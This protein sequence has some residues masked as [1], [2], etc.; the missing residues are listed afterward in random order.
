MTIKTRLYRLVWRLIVKPY[1]DRVFKPEWSGDFSKIVTAERWRGAW[2][3]TTER[4]VYVLG[5]R[6]DFIDLSI[7]RTR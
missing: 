1:L 2:I 5:D 4:S 3:I 7:Q 6:L